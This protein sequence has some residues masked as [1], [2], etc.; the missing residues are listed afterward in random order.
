MAGSRQRSREP[1]DEF[2]IDH[3]QRAVGLYREFADVAGPV[4]PMKPSC[5]RISFLLIEILPLFS[6]NWRRHLQMKRGARS[7]KKKGQRSLRTLPPTRRGNKVTEDPQVKDALFP[8]S[9]S[10]YSQRY[11]VLVKSDFASYVRR[12]GKGYGCLLGRYGLANPYRDSTFCADSDKTK[13]TNS[14]ARV[15]LGPPATTAIGYRIGR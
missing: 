13:R 9:L 7:T 14:R 2:L 1:G 8:H 6:A 15:W 10:L 5:T 3:L 12:S 4:G 11:N